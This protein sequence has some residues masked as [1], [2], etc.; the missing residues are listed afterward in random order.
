MRRLSLL[1]AGIAVV[2]IVALEFATRR[3]QG[4][5]FVSGF[6]EAEDV[7]VGSRVGGRVEQVHVAEGDRVAAGQKL[8][9]LAP[10]DLQER[11][12]EASAVLAARQAQLAKLEAGFRPEEI[13]QARAR[14]DQAQ[15]ALD[16]ALAGPR[17]LEI[18][19]LENLVRA[20][21][22]DAVKA[23][24]DFARIQPLYTAGQASGD[25]MTN[26]TWALARAEAKLAEA[27]DQ[28]ALSRE[29]T[30]AEDIAA[31]KAAFAEAEAGL[32]LLEAGH[33]AED[34]A[35]AR[36]EVASA[37]AAVSVIRRQLEELN[38]VS[39]CDC[40]VDAFELQPGDVVAANAPV[41]AL[42]DPSRMWVRA[43][44]PEN[45]LDVQLGQKM[46]VR[47]DSFPD[48]TFA[49][50]VVFIASEAEFTPANVQTVEE[51]SKQVFRI[52]VALDE[53]RDR[54]R[55]GMAADVYP[56]IAP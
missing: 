19:I 36:A 20:A 10:F 33:R 56:E 1:I 8:V 44:L 6:I 38:I 45:R 16:K 21:E 4:P 2:A 17:P 48:R 7:R 29:G 5:F 25:E 55:P 37:E 51:R 9:T 15:A 35:Q 32:A 23:K 54:L 30:R 24:A 42:L 39:P 3:Q 41:A 34:V 43:Y 53:G 50:H 13:A 27:R 18:S 12:A 31:A 26:A 46:S 49:G 28:L 52:K 14:R 22:A 47:V 40:V 11:L